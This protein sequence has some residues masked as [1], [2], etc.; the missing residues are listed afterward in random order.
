[1]KRD[2]IIQ[3][4]AATLGL[5]CLGLSG[6]LSSSISNSAGRHQLTYAD[7]A[8]EGDPPEVALGI[9]MGAFRGIFVNWLWFRA[10]EMKEKGQYYEAMELAR[11]ITTL[12]P[13]FP[14]VWV[15]HAWNMAYN[16]SVA[17]NTPEE[18]WQWVNA[19]VRLLRKDGIRANPNDMLLHKEL[20]W[21]FLH[22]IAGITDDA[23]QYYKRQVAQE[24]TIVLGDPPARSI[25][26]RTREGAT[27][28][29]VAWLG[30]IAGAPDT[31]EAL[32]AA[33]PAAGELFDKVNALTDGR[34]PYD[35]L[36][37]YESHHAMRTSIFRAQAEASMG[38]QNRAFASL[39]DD[40]QF[41]AA[42]PA[43]LNHLRRRLLLDEYNMEPERMIRYTRKYGPIDW[44]HP[45]AHALYWSARGVEESLGRWTD[46]SRRD[47]DFINT[48]RVTIQALQ[49]LYRSG[50]VYFNFFD[51]IAGNS[52]AY[53]L[54]PNAA[55]VESYGEVL[56]ELID[57]S[58]ADQDKRPY[59]VYSAGYE[60]FLRDAIR[61]F[62]RRGQKDLAQEYYHR[63]GT[64]PRQN[65]ND[66][67]FQVDVSMKL[68]AF[69][70]KELQDDRV[71]SPYVMVSEVM[72]SLQGAYVNGLLAGDD[73]V[74]RTGFEWARQA[75]RYYYETQVRD[76]V[77]G[78][79]DTRTGVL[80][81]DFRIVAGDT[82]ARI[83]QLMRVD[84]ASFMFQRAPVDLQ[85]FA[86][87][88]L[89]AAWKPEIDTQAAAGTGRPFGELFPEPPG[90]EAHR[91]Y[92]A[93]VR[94]EREAKRA[95]LEQ[96]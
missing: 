57:R 15:F 63:L 83:I 48:D 4:G 58:W 38:E 44:R 13:R 47:Y 9:A 2:T 23:N 14:Q 55:F 89:L 88:F 71:R 32:R 82:F 60:N 29:F 56:E 17:T 33:D 35:I 67:F 11:A 20:A 74:F 94:A 37:R 93:Q 1:M 6:G 28:Q 5:A 72:G 79:A 30:G 61:F 90:M 75:H 87:D 62:Y 59:T 77:A 45:A 46:E 36:R 73:E 25:E 12:Q 10:N 21:I 52:G 86:Y 16:I 64:Y 39:M 19:G 34:G 27:E 92:L 53:Q 49:E 8:E 96:N 40:P 76:I 65:I 70:L 68:D 3:L 69:V 84:Q 42:W 26:S 24:W 91:A 85:Q 31:I 50:D 95:D 78:G 22:K 54:A 81:P 51:S 43:L 18:R 41:K 66:P 80:D 7:T